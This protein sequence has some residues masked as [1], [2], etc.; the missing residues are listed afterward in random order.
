MMESG[1]RQNNTPQP[2]RSII[3]HPSV[4]DIFRNPVEHHKDIG[5]HRIFELIQL[6][7]ANTG[8]IKLTAGSGSFQPPVR[9]S[10]P[11]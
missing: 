3:Q 10:D 2:L 1:L 11:E 7:A 5:K 4:A 6:Y 9:Q 8:Q